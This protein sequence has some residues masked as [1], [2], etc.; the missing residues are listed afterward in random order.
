MKEKFVGKYHFIFY[1]NYERYIIPTVRY[2]PKSESSSASLTFAFLRYRMTV[3]NNESDKEMISYAS[4]MRDCLKIALTDT[5]ESRFTD[6]HTTLKDMYDW[7]DSFFHPA[8]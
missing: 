1:R 3:L 6:Y 4:N 8:V 7:I 5:D 2:C